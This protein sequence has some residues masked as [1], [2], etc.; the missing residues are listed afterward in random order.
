M[1]AFLLCAGIGSRLRPLTERIPK[2]LA[3]ICGK[4]LL[5]IWLETLAEI[6][7]TSFLI[8]THHMADQVYN[9]IIKSKF[10]DQVELVYEPELLGTAGSIR[11]WRDKLGQTDIFLCHADNLCVCDFQAFLTAYHTRSAGMLGTMMTFTTDSPESCG[12]V[13]TDDLGHIL[14]YW[15]KDPNAYGNLANAAVYV[16]T[17]EFCDIVANDPN[18]FDLSKDSIP[19]L[20]PRMNS[21]HNAILHRDIGTLSSYALAQVDYPIAQRQT[22]L[23]GHEAALYGRGA[24][25]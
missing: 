10:S 23:R 13:K 2:C 15:E 18:A 1:K 11:Q 21:F 16:V 17:A 12:I 25:L 5:Q 3:P 8:N 20:Y 19:H 6:G 22:L 9:F 24:H 4:P 7:V 14:S